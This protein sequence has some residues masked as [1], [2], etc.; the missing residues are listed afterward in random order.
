[1]T[2]RTVNGVVLHVSPHPDDELLGAP[3]A[4]MALRD[5]GHQVLN[6]VVSLG[7]RPDH[8]RRRKEAEVACDRAGFDVVF[9]DPPVDI[10]RDNLVDAQAEVRRLV[11]EHLDERGPSAVVSPSPH[12]RHHGHEVVAR[13]VRE[14]LRGRPDPPIWWMWGLWGALPFPN[15]FVP[16]DEDRREEIV[17]ALEAHAGE[18]ARNDYLR[19]VGARGLA[20][21]VLGPELIHEFGAPG[22]DSEYADLLS[23]VLRHQGG[24][25]LGRPRDLDP[26]NA[27]DTEP[28]KKADA[29]VD[30]PSLSQ[31]SA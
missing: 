9:A 15:L 27:F 11:E 13:G 4:L 18:I 29:W 23:E 10:S 28:H 1:L 30:A 7:R 5:A 22:R 16:F 6:L 17:A 21:V 12:D 20:N 31:L 2:E 14:A 8:S 25:W 26:A 19:L 24:W 3:A